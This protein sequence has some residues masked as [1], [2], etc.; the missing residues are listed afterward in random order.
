MKLLMKIKTES[1]SEM[2]RPLVAVELKVVVTVL[3]W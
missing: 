2:L 1:Q 3:N